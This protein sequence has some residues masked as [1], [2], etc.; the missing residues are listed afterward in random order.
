M[1]VSCDARQL[2]WRCAAELSGDEVAIKEIIGGEDTH[3]LNQIAFGLPSRLVA[4]VYLFRTIFRGSGWS[5]ANDPDFMHV[6]ADS[7]YWDSV[8][9]KF[10]AKYYG[11]DKKHKEW[12]ELV[13]SGKPIVGP[14]GREW[15]ISN[16]DKQGV[17]F[18]PWTT[19]TNFPIQGTGAD[20]M[21]IGR[22]SAFNRIKRMKNSHEIKFIQTVHD[23]LTLDCPE[24]RTKEC[25]RMFYEVFRDLQLNI[26]KLFNYEWV[27][28]LEGEVKIGMNQASFKEMKYEEACA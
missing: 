11:L 7:K 13:M 3:S 27:V 2:E 20:V 26:K 21:M 28:P 24:D 19:L 14:L 15:P 17:L 23:S 10:Y 9:E 25:V 16:R 1:L 22:V 5:F 8:N 12:A 4:K 6:S 18:T